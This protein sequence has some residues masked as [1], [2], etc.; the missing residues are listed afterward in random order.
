MQP[1][2]HVFNCDLATA[3]MSIRELQDALPYARSAWSSDSIEEQANVNLLVCLRETSADNADLDSIVRHAS[4]LGSRSPSLWN[5]VARGYRHLGRP[6]LALRGCNTAL[7]L[8]PSYIPALCLASELQMDLGYSNQA[9]DSLTKLGDLDPDHHGKRSLLNLTHVYGDVKK[10]WA[11]ALEHA[12][13]ARGQ[14]PGDEDAN[15]AYQKVVVGISGSADA[16]RDLVGRFEAL[17]HERDDLR[18]V[19]EGFRAGEKGLPLGV[20]LQRLEGQEIEFME[21]FPKRADDLAKEIAAFGTSNDGTIF[22]GVADN[23]AVVGLEDV[24]SS[25]ERDKLQ[26]RIAGI[27]GG[28]VAPPISVDVYFVERDGSTVVKIFVEKGPEPVYLAGTTPYV[29]HLDQSR[30]ATPEELKRLY[31]ADSSK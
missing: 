4:A 6:Q 17:H 7:A 27:T 15:S 9:I 19:F 21:R 22:L 12:V 18:T 20:A 23:G 28:T 29:R 10:D 30:P 1:K 24:G 5:Q 11:A 2:N 16:T 13:R 26:N 8:D 31:R 14:F 3:L 25:Q